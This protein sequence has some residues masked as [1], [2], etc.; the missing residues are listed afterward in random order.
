VVTPVELFFKPFI[1]SLVGFLIEGSPMSCF[2]AE[3]PGA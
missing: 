1:S 3:L 2:A